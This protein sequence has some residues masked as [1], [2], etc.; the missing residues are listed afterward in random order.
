MRFKADGPA[1]PDILLD[2]RD[3]GNVVFLCGAGVSIPAGMPDFLNLAR[4]VTHELGPPSDSVIRRALQTYDQTGPVAEWFG[5]S[6]DRVFQML[7]QEYGREQV[8]KIVWERLNEP[9]KTQR[10]HG[11]I[12]RLSANPEG[13]PQ[14]V[15]TNFDRLFETA[16]GQRANSIYE[17][18]MYPDLRSV[19]ATGITYLHGRLAAT[20]SDTHNYILSSADLGR[21]YLVEGWAGKFVRE[22]LQHY[23]VVL[24]GYQ[25]EDPP[26]SYLL[27]GLDSVGQRTPNL[28]AFDSGDREE[29]QAK[30]RD[31]GVNAIPYGDDH[32]ALWETLEAWAE[33]ADDPAAWRNAVVQLSANG[34]RALAPHERGM[35]A[36]LV[37]STTGAKQFA[38]SK[39]AP[40]AE[41]LCVFDASCRYANPASGLGG[42]QQPFDPLE[43]YGLDDDPPRTHA[44]EQRNSARGDDL[45]S[46]R[47]GDDSVD[48]W[49]S[50]SRSWVPPHDPIPS[51]LFHLAGWM[52]SC[53]NDPILAW[54]VARQPALHPR[55]HRMLK[56]TV[57]DSID[58]IDKAR[59]GW[60]VLLEALEGGTHPTTDANLVDL[61]KQI[62]ERGWTPGLILTFEALTEP[63]FDAGPPMTIAEPR[64]PSGEWS[65]VEWRA[66]TNLSIRFPPQWVSWPT[67]PDDDLPSVY[68]ALERNLLRASEQLREIGEIGWDV[69]DAHPDYHSDRNAYVSLVRELLA[70]LSALYPGRVKQRIAL[71]PDPDPRMFDRL[72]LYMWSKSDLFSGTE[73]VE[74]VLALSDDQFWRDNGPG[75]LMCL[76]RTRWGDFPAKQRRLIGQR[77]L[78]GPPRP[79]DDDEARGQTMAASR[80]GWLVQAGCAF[81]DDLVGQWKTLKGNLPGWDDNWV[82]DAVVTPEVQISDVEIDE[83]ASVLEGVPVGGIV[84]VSLEHSGRT[85]PSVVNEPFTG[86][87]KSRPGRA[88]RALSAAARRG[89][90]PVHLWSSALRHWPDNAPRRA[91]R[92]L[93]GRLRRLPPATIVAMSY[94]VGHW[95]K[96]RFPDATSDDRVLAFGVFDHLVESLLATGSEGPKSLWAERTIGASGVQASRPNFTRAINAPIGKAAEGLL[97]VLN[98]DKPEQGAGLREDFKV[99]FERLQSASGEGADDAVCVLSNQIA[100]LNWVDPSWVDAKMIPWFRP[101]HDRGE[102]AWSGILSSPWGS[103]RPLFVEI[104]DGFLDLPNR[105]YE[106]GWRREAQR[107]CHEIV[108]LAIPDGRRLPFEDAR[109]CLRRIKPEGRERVIW[110]LGR[111]GADNDDGWRNFVVPF[112]R[113]AWPNERQYRTSGTSGAWLRLLCHTGDV[114]PDL[115]DAV[116]NHLGAVDGHQ[117]SLAGLEPLAKRFPEQTLDLLNHVVPDGVGYAPY[118][119]SWVL[120]LLVE[121]EPAL[122]GDSR[123]SRLHRLAAQQ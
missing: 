30:W 6:L 113:K 4:H 28:F 94:P 24:L 104:K 82:D 91:T 79:D 60:M 64:P 88:V 99:R 121:A 77:I 85:T 9:P 63:V 31:R 68:V 35:V 17:P 43:T 66:V 81:P 53:V 49:Q 40:P 51:R 119:L 70:R 39:P 22:L 55:L 5:P 123:Y 102:S 109:R 90:F 57:E 120:D 117:V 8:T 86:L 115:L 111:V 76:L 25:A 59:R 69:D 87:V 84:A 106:W 118:R 75:E 52:V 32:E 105:M 34:P 73:T 16:L 80:F 29:D 47:R 78:D 62:Q 100:W 18:P 48:R 61:S 98:R 97:E 72:R 27:Q 67:A 58:L 21:A 114:F 108:A 112:I 46:W 54:W 2:E 42:F 36:Q 116:R 71:W 93:H 19:P 10:H 13:D 96:E 103:I 12:A 44:G 110:F 50:L 7:Y 23:T 107:Y 74:H 15:T 101:D 3:A 20:E 95:L 11:I 122:N 56:R 45:I 89:E 38:S 1:I 14:I 26:V 83:D 37:R 41:W 65:D 33:R 92:V